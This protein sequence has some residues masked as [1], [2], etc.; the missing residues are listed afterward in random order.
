MVQHEEVG[1]RHWGS[2]EREDMLNIGRKVVQ[3]G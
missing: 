2:R 3:E 1:P